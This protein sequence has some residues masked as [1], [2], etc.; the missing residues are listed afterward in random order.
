[1]KIQKR[2]I[3]HAPNSAAQQ[4]TIYIL[5]L[6]DKELVLKDEEL[7]LEGERRTELEAGSL[8]R[9]ERLR[10]SAAMRRMLLRMRGVSEGQA[11]TLKAIREGWR[12]EGVVEGE[13]KWSNMRWQRHLS[14]IH[15]A[16]G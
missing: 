3:V 2:S 7:V 5:V 12:S 6:E 8:E 4:A 14:G 16:S 13:R 15:A 9:N 1:M 10:W 11:R